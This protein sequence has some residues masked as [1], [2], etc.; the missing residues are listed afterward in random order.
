[1]LGAPAWGP[2][3]RSPE[4]TLKENKTDVAP[5]LAK[6]MRF[7]VSEPSPKNVERNRGKHPV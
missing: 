3:F 5:V 4:S 6:S 2:E 7:E 1:M